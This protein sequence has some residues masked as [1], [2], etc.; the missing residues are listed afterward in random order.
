MVAANGFC[1]TGAGIEFFDDFDMADRV[2]SRVEV[3]RESFLLNNPNDGMLLCC[4]KRLGDGREAGW[5][6]VVS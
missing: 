4:E 6:A 2:R 5:H 1:V 3:L